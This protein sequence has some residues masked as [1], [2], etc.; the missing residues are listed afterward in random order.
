MSGISAIV[1]ELKCVLNTFT[2]H[3]HQI[4]N[5]YKSAFS[6]NVPATTCRVQNQTSLHAM[7]SNF[8][9]T[10]KKKTLNSFLV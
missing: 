9:Q 1:P 4:C 3:G 8:T 5:S 7:G 6:Q 2:Y 10:H